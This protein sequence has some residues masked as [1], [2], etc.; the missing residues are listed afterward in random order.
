MKPF[1]MTL[2]VVILE[3]VVTRGIDASQTVK[4]ILGYNKDIL[5]YEVENEHGKV[6]DMFTQKVVV[7]RLL[8][9]YAVNPLFMHHLNMAIAIQSTDSQLFIFARC[10]FYSGITVIHCM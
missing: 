6:C 4:H 8:S 10:K 9:S 7:T 3:F 5:S 1:Q 2:L